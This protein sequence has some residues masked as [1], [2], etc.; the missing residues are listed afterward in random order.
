MFNQSEIFKDLDP[1]LLD[2]EYVFCT[3]PSSRYGEHSNLEPLASFSEKE[4]LTLVLLKETA[5]LNSLNFEGIFRCISLNLI[6]SLTCVGLTAKI[7][8]LLADNK[9]SANIY[10]GYY[11]DHI[12][13]PRD[14]SKEAIKLLCNIV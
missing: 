11:H 10:A 14:K 8:R 12:F 3:F 2:K 6:S 5:Q 7:S 4:G 1:V 9:I 13:V